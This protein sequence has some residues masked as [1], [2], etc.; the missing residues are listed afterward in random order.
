MTEHNGIQVNDTQKSEY[1]TQHKDPQKNNIWHNGI[2][3][4]NT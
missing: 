2:E 1:D 4:N 3:H